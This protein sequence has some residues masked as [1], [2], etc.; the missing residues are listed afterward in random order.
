MNLNTEFE[1]CAFVW[2]QHTV[3]VVYMMHLDP[4]IGDDCSDMQN[5]LSVGRKAIVHVRW[6]I[7]VHPQGY[8]VRLIA[9]R[10]VLR[11]QKVSSTLQEQP[12]DNTD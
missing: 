12:R 11:K 6:I 7:A 4:C 8:I 9:S 3:V 5:Q 1:L 10:R 2:C